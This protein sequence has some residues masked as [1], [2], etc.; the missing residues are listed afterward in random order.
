LDKPHAGTASGIDGK[1][2]IKVNSTFKIL[3][4]RIV[5]IWRLG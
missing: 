2:Q 3:V 5:R 4:F 1:V